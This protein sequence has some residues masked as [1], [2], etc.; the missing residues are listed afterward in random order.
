VVPRDEGV[1]SPSRPRHGTSKRDERC[2]PL[3]V[4][5]MNGAL[6]GAEQPLRFGLASARDGVRYDRDGRGRIEENG[7]R[8]RRG[9]TRSGRRGRGG[10]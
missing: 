9:G 8:M 3:C 6:V 5:G 1:S 7:R 2:G 10:G 4:V